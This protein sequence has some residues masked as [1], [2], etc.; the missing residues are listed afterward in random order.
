MLLEQRESHTL[1]LAGKHNERIQRINY[2]I[3][4]HHRLPHKR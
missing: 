3:H 2:Q 1:E 4:S